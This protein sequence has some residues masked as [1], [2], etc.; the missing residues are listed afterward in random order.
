MSHRE[1][2]AMAGR[3]VHPPIH[4]DDDGAI[5]GTG[6]TFFRPSV[7]MGRSAPFS[8]DKVVGGRG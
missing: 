6:K 2:E 8:G 3:A 4:K 1:T 7:H 5:H